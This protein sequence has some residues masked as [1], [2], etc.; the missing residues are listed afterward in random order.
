MMITAPI[1][2]R[3]VLT[4]PLVVRKHLL[5]A[6]GQPVKG[7]FQIQFAQLLPVLAQCLRILSKHTIMAQTGSDT[8]LRRH[9]LKG[10]VTHVSEGNEQASCVPCLQEGKRGDLYS[11]N[12]NND[13]PRKDASDATRLKKFNRL[14]AGGTARDISPK[15]Q[16]QERD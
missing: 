12:S 4:C 14:R 7:C 3:D 8:H 2:V 10:A 5:Q 15:L 9:R 6:Q 13:V 16:A 1:T 11:C